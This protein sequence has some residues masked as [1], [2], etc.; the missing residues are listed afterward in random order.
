MTCPILRVRGPRTSDMA[1]DYPLQA[2]KV[3][4]TLFCFIFKKMILSNFLVIGNL[5][6][7]PAP[8]HYDIP[9]KFD[10]K[11]RS[12]PLNSTFGHARRDSLN[13]SANMSRS[14]CNE[15]GVGGRSPQPGPGQYNDFAAK[16][17]LQKGPSFTF[18][19]KTKFQDFNE[20]NAGTRNVPG[21]G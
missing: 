12:V 20:I 15:Q 14:F 11:R 17:K 9:S 2:P 4:F 19:G 18:K 8:G 10:I 21:P 7:S 13:G 3:V 5:N 16:D 6:Y 1:R